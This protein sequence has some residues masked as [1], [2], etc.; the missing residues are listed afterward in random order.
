MTTTEYER[1]KA[2]I[3]PGYAI[4]LRSSANPLKYRAIANATNLDSAR[5]AGKREA[6]KCVNDPEQPVRWAT[7][8]AAPYQGSFKNDVDTL[9]EGSVVVYAT[10]SVPVVNE[11]KAA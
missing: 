8:Y 4:Y 3:E 10:G 6:L 11:R 5:A 1:L 9:P 7:T 2:S